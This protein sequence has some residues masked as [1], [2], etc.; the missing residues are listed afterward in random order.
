MALGG[1]GIIAVHRRGEVGRGGEGWGVGGTI[2]CGGTFEECDGRGG[3]VGTFYEHRRRGVVVARGWHRGDTVSRQRMVRGSTGRN[4]L[5]TRGGRNQQRRRRRQPDPPPRLPHP[6]F[7]ERLPS[8]PPPRRTERLWSTL[9]LPHGTPPYRFRSAPP[10]LGRRPR[11]QIRR[12]DGPFPLPVIAGGVRYGGIG[13]GRDDERTRWTHEGMDIGG[14]GGMED[15]MRPN[16]ETVSERCGCHRYRWVERLVGHGGRHVV[17]PAVRG[18]GDR[19]GRRECCR[20]QDLCQ[21]GGGGT[22]DGG[23][24]RADERGRSTIRR[25]AREIGE[26]SVPVSTGVVAQIEREAKR[27]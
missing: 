21:G 13:R 10:P 17:R 23:T 6:P 20:G 4:L 24:V 26:G 9:P 15:R 18:D 16:E 11:S 5:L 8:L 22:H 25:V 7:G 12:Y 3:G 27:G 14:I 1:G 2:E 19:G